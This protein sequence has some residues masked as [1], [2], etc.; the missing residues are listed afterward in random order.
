MNTIDISELHNYSVEDWQDY[1][2]EKQSEKYVIYL[3]KETLYGYSDKVDIA[4]EYG[5]AAFIGEKLKGAS[6]EFSYHVPDPSQQESF[7][8]T[9][10]PKSHEELAEILALI[11][12]GI[13]SDDE[14]AESDFHEEVSGYLYGANQDNVACPELL[15]VYKTYNIRTELED[16]A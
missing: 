2:K 3:P 6:E 9:I 13:T 1:L 10:K 16:Q 7:D 4:I 11:T 8:F 12:T 15:E 14:E 5:I